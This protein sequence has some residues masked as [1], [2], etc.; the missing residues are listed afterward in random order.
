MTIAA[1]PRMGK[2]SSSLEAPL[3]DQLEK[4]AAFEPRNAPVISL[5]LNLAPDQHGRDN[6][7]TFCRKSFA[8]RLKAYREHSPE[9]TSLERDVERINAY[10]GIEL[11]RSA[12][13]LALFASA[14]SEGFFEAVQLDVPFE[15]HWL[16]VGGVPHIYPLVRLIDQHPRYAVVV[17]DTH[18]ARI[19]V[20][21]LGSVEKRRQVTGVKTRRSSVGGWSQARY[22][23]RA[24]NFHLHHIKEVVDTLDRVVRADNIQHI[25]VA[26]NDVA[27]PLLR[28]AMPSHL[29]EQVVSVLRL[30]RQSGEDEIAEV[31]REVLRQKDAETDGEQIAEVIGAWQGGGLGVVGPEATLRAVQMGQVEELL[32]VGTPQVLKTVQRSDNDSPEPIAAET[33]AADGPHEKQLRFADELVTWAHQT[34]AR[35]RIIESP[36]LLADHGGVAARL[37]FRI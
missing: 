3:R 16:F 24:E 13:G 12:N 20:F 26:G 17:L 25:V 7:E 11:N 14:A 22:Q 19:L 30:D 37:R 18:H 6:Y 36:E 2:T 10:L 27:V 15:D 32:I 8:Q 31:T 23:R 1:P 21:G 9:R 5:Y 34:G 35:V 33:S 29:N 28:E 4:L